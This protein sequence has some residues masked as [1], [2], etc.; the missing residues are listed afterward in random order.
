MKNKTKTKRNKQ[1]TKP[2]QCQLRVNSPCKRTVLF[3]WVCLPLSHEY[4]RSGEFIC[5]LYHTSNVV[6]ACCFTACW[7]KKQLKHTLTQSWPLTNRLIPSENVTG[8]TNDRKWV[9]SCTELWYI[10]TQDFQSFFCLC[11]IST[12]TGHLPVCQCVTLDLPW[13]YHAQIWQ[14]RSV[15]RGCF[16]VHML[17]TVFI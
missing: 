11:F 15:S 17:I 5:V 16:C 10:T 9:I 6:S 8:T 13:W 2:T 12:I 3:P 14:L 7:V 1:K 4:G